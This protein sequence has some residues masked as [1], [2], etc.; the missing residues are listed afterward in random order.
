M[1][2]PF[3]YDDA[4]DG[5]LADGNPLPVLSLDLGTNTV[6]GTILR[7]KS[8]TGITTLDDDYFALDVPTG[9]ALDSLTIDIAASTGSPPEAAMPSA[10]KIPIPG[11]N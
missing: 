1:P 7:T 11:R 5:D 6:F 4:F 10:R 3:A 8:A 2:P 9:T